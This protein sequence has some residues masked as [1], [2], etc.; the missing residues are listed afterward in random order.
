MTTEVW[1]HLHF[2]VAVVRLMAEKPSNAAE[3]PQRTDSS[4]GIT[5]M[6]WCILDK[7]SLQL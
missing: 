4:K 7:N 2:Y 3:A 1:S 6:I 5:N